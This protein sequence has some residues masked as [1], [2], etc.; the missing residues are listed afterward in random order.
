MLGMY[1]EK[2]PLTVCLIGVM[3]ENKILLARRK[4]PPYSGYWGLLGGRQT[5]GKKIEEVVKSEVLEET[6]FRVKNKINVNGL[7]SEILLDENK[8]PKHHFL[9]LVTKA[10]LDES[11]ER[12]NETEN[13]DIQ[14]FRWFDFPLNK[15]DEEKIIPTDLIMLKNFNSNNLVFKEFVMK[16]EKNKLK[17]IKV[18]E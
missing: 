9:F 16:E 2:N 3:H 14:E 15:E 12:K 1:E 8:K 10:E 13:T 6:G 4:R 18:I 7:Y 5:F 11:F 17:L